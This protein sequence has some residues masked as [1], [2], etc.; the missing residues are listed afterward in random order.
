[1]V[2]VGTK[3]SVLQDEKEKG[4]PGLEGRNKPEKKGGRGPV[5]KDRRRARVVGV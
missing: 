4:E 2:C 5:R 1:M 3:G